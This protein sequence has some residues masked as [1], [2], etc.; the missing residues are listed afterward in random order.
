MLLLAEQSLFSKSQAL[1]SA[2]RP[3]PVGSLSTQCRFER[4]RMILFYVLKKEYYKAPHWRASEQMSVFKQLWG[5]KSII[6]SFIQN[7]S[8]LQKQIWKQLVHLFL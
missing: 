1:L 4:L 3:F 5:K 2:P 6:K 8:N 7:K